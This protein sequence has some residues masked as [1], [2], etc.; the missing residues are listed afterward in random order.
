MIESLMLHPAILVA[1]GFETLNTSDMRFLQAY[2]NHFE[3]AKELH[4]TCIYR[5]QDF[6][7]GG[8]LNPESEYFDINEAFIEAR[9]RIDSFPYMTMYEIRMHF[10]Y[11]RIASIFEA[12][13]S[14]LYKELE[15]FAQQY[16]MPLSSFLDT[17]RAIRKFERN[18]IYSK[19]LALHQCGLGNKKSR[20]FE[21]IIDGFISLQRSKEMQKIRRL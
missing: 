10:Y 16:H 14:E 2:R 3:E 13:C 21:Y 11:G 5:P 7:L 9:D 20:A 8:I 15:F 4:R 17:S 6:L 1:K 12:L 18:S 19:I